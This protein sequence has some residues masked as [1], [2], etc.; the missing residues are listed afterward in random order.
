MYR[1]ICNIK[2]VEDWLNSGEYCEKM[3]LKVYGGKHYK[4][5]II[6]MIKID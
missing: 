1:F 6:K 2:E 4:N 5:L 3:S